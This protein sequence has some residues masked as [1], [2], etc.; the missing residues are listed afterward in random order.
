VA[1]VLDR[2]REFEPKPRSLSANLQWASL[3]ADGVVQNEDL[4][5]SRS[6]QFLG[7]DT[8][9][10]SPEELNALSELM[11]KTLTRLGSEVMLHL[12]A[13][14][15]A[16]APEPPRPEVSP[17]KV[18]YLFA[19][20][21]Y[22][23]YAQNP[24][25]ETR[26]VATLTFQPPQKKRQRLARV[27]LRGLEEEGAREGAAHVAKFE[28]VC[29]LFENHLGQAL[30]MSRLES[31]EQLR[32]LYSCLTGLDRPVAVPMHG[33]R[34]SDALSDQEFLGGW[35]PQIGEKHIR[36][37]RVSEYPGTE[38]VPA[39][40]SALTELPAAY[41]WST[42]LV[43]VR[44]ELGRARAERERLRWF[45]KRRGWR[46][47]LRGATGGEM[48]EADELTLQD[49][50]A[51]KFAEDAKNLLKRL[52]D[53][54]LVRYTTKVV[55]LED[56]AETAAET[57]AQVIKALNSRGFGAAVEEANTIDAWLGSL[58]GH[59]SQDLRRDPLPSRSVA[60]LLPITGSWSG[61]ATNPSQ[62]LPP[63]TPPL[64]WTSADG[65]TPFRLHL[66]TSDVGHSLVLGPTGAGKSYFLS[67][68]LLSWIANYPNAQVFVFDKGYS[69]FVPCLA[70]GGTHYD[71]G[72]P[73]ALPF[74]PLRHVDESAERAWALEWV[75]L[76]LRLQ[77]LETTAYQRQQIQRGLELLGK[78]PPEARTLTELSELV[79]EH[80]IREALA[81]YCEGG[82]LENLLDGSTD[83]LSDN[84][85]LCF[86]LGRI[87]DRHERALVPVQIYLA[88]ALAKRRAA[89]RPTLLIWDEAWRALQDRFCRQWIRSDLATARKQNCAVMLV[90]QSFAQVL[91]E[92]GLRT[93]LDEAA[94][95]K[96]FLPNP[97]AMRGENARQYEAL[98]VPTEVC[99]LI[100]KM[101]PKRDYL[102]HS[103]FAS[104]IFHLGESTF[105]HALLTPP[106]NSTEESM[107]EEVRRRVATHGPN[108]LSGYL[109]EREGLAAWVD[110][111]NESTESA[112]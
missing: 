64:L 98:G 96:I 8:R 40:L 14:R 18:A 95:T 22:Q 84:Y 85:Y 81:V 99:E 33:V 52:Y 109:R 82:A 60:D 100:A 78:Q 9:V 70:A 102:Y 104:R 93:L 48:S 83:P 20:E 34:V 107:V 41:R 94:Q 68:A 51:A 75:D 88:H 108:W 45:E 91:D 32:H 50:G 5:L 13:V 6:W 15:T 65:A 101:Q 105:G 46:A 2:V 63:E 62:Y 57:A 7:V 72:A 80:D 86:E 111:L 77:N 42:R 89:S 58:P 106:H 44:P 16:V 49:A 97:A 11:S 79:P 87:M 71:V 17:S 92:D 112:A 90:T 10:A 29:R 37:V 35:R 30:R 27:F 23:I 31:K 47:R 1:L 56:S 110:L 54:A 4:A 12:D 73:G 38:T 76:V 69:N 74:Q 67:H 19:L 24:H 21:R 28:E 43:P 66:H 3:P 25:F 103:R 39:L 26:F 36:V 53:E 61:F 59:G 55:I